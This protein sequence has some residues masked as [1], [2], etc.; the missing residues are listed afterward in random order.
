MPA[1]SGVI[2]AL[3]TPPI[4]SLQQVLDTNGPYGAG[5]HTIANFHTG[6][7]F[8]LPAGTYPISGTY[9]VLTVINGAIPPGLGLEIGWQDSGITDD[10]DI[11][12]DRTLQL[13]IEHQLP[14]TGAYVITNL[15][16]SYRMT[17]LFL[18]QGIVD[19][20]S[21]IGL[22]VAPNLSFDLYF[23]CVL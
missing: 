10:G 5:S 20:P 11:Y 9:G 3:A 7:A 6:G 18:W 22:Y 17:E 1:T 4:A 19:A 21:R 8:I 15:Y 2:D 16:S 13:A 12:Y 14:I 23:M